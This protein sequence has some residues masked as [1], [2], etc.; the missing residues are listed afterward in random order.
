MFLSDEAGLSTTARS[1]REGSTYY[2]THLSIHVSIAV[3]QT[4]I[5]LRALA[6][7]KLI[8]SRHMAPAPK[9]S[10]ERT[11]GRS[12]L[13]LDYQAWSALPSTLVLLKRGPAQFLSL[14]FERPAY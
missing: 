6:V 1:S 3:R 13:G 4:D 2:Y 14:T 7:P 12:R 8:E 5:P 9:S 11:E 10:R